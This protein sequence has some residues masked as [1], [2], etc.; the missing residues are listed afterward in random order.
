MHR[1]TRTKLLALIFMTA[2]AQGQIARG[3]ITDFTSWTLVQD[4]ANANFTSSV[5]ATQATLL[6][7]NGAIPAA[8]DIGY[9]SVDGET[10]AGSSAGYAFDPANNF[11][12]AIDFNISFSNTPTG[13]LAI[14][15]GVGE[16][17]DGMNSAGAVLLLNNGS[18][19]A[20]FGAAARIDDQTQ[21]PQAILVL[22]SLSGSLFASYDVASG[23]ITLGASQTA[24]AAAPS[25]TTTFSGLQNSWNNGDLLTSFFLRSDN[26]LGQAW[27]SGNGQAVFSNFRVLSGSPTAVPEPTSLTFLCV[28]G[29]ALSRLRNRRF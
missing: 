23:N 21:T 27:Q 29:F 19:S 4:P 5:S 8:T 20:V 17:R 18:P 24:G 28:S 11:Q 7:G 10:P 1:L 12:V 9:Q 2:I 13:G 25:G 14:G 16:D 3:A 26:T 15:F 6:A 22:G